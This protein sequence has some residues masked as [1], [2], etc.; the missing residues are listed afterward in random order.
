MSA[1]RK[2]ATSVSKQAA[3]WADHWA[4]LKVA[5]R[6]ACWAGKLAA[7]LAAPSDTKLVGKRAHRK[8]ETLA[9]MQAVLLADHWAVLKV[10]SRVAYWA[11]RWAAR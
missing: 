10:A 1:D 2:A 7:Q 8:A 3:L 6:V 5:S 9:L 11:G 4:V